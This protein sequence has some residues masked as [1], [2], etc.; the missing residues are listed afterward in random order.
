MATLNDVIK[1]LENTNVSG[2][3][4]I[5]D[6]VKNKKEASELLTSF[7]GALGRRVG[8]YKDMEKLLE[9][10]IEL[11]PK[12]SVAYYNLGCLHTEPEV[13]DRKPALAEKALGEYRK[14][15][16][17]DGEFI[18]ARCNLALLLAYLGKAEEAW[19]EYDRI[20]D[21]DPKNPDKYDSIEGVIKSRISQ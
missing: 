4:D 16:E 14:A 19:E 17:L 6:N 21:L 18:K 15:V 10:A 9:K 13:L 2:A 20:L 7:A 1:L 12:N 3:L 11:H 8:A 5:V